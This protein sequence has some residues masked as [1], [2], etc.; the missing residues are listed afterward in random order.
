MLLYNNYNTLICAQESAQAAVSVTRRWA[1]EATST[2]SSRDKEAE[3]A[4]KVVRMATVALAL[5]VAA[6]QTKLAAATC[7][8]RARHSSAC[9]HHVLLCACRGGCVLTGVRVC[10]ARV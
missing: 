5:A 6:A 8:M 4:E 9:V 2:Q 10:T 3:L 7:V 1:Q